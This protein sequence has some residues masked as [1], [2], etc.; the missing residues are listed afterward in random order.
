MSCH[1]QTKTPSESK[2]SIF[3]WL[4][5]WFNSKVDAIITNL[6][7]EHA[8]CQDSSRRGSRGKLADKSV[9]LQIIGND[10]ANI[11]VFSPQH[12]Y[13]Y[14]LYLSQKAGIIKFYKFAK[15]DYQIF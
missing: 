5:P 6:F 15:N 1:E 13:W 10:N 9:F 2:N 3:L 7:C 4:R 14:Q 12:T 8:F 11:S